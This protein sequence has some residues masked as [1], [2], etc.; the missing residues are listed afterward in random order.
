MSLGE[1]ISPFSIS[2]IRGVP[3]NV[4]SLSDARTPLA[5]FVNNLLN[6]ARDHPNEQGG[7]TSRV[8]LR[9]EPS[10]PRVG[11]VSPACRGDANVPEGR[12][13]ALASSLAM[14]APQAS[15]KD[16]RLGAASILASGRRA[17]LALCG[18]RGRSD[19]GGP[20]GVVAVGLCQQDRDPPA[21]QNS[22]EGESLRS[23]LAYVLSRPSISDATL[24]S[25]APSPISSVVIVRLGLTAGLRNGLSRMSGNHHV[26]FLGE[27][28]VEIPH[29]YPT[30]DR[31]GV[32]ENGR[33]EDFTRVYKAESE[34]PDRDDV[35]ADAG[36]LGI[37]TTDEELLAIEP[38]KAWAQRRARGS[39][40]GIATGN[41]SWGW[42]R[43]G[44]RVADSLPLFSFFCL[45]NVLICCGFR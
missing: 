21:S 22:S 20:C 43:R 34:C 40:S 29:P 17:K 18:R 26:R 31:T 44:C 8:D 39:G 7:V 6:G 35:H 4:E 32:E 13:C 38:S 12:S 42:L 41:L 11:D 9:P 15:G 30:N 10:A 3:L 27:D 24:A 2:N 5:G 19:A 36:V 25:A 45:C 1:R 33:F 23:E 16:R 37:E 28:A 14:G